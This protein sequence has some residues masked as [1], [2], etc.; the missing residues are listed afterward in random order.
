MMS[1][2]WKRW[3][4][5]VVDGRFTLGAF[6]GCSDHSAVFIT[7]YGQQGRNAAIKFVE[8]NPISAPVQLSRW[9]RASKLSHPHLIRILHWGRCQ[10]GKCSM[11]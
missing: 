6:Q 8:A 11:W 9:E 2:A 1:E 5:S 7:K 10:L 4:G 3:E